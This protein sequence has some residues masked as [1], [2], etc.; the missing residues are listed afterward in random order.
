MHIQAGRVNEAFSALTLFEA[1]ATSDI[2]CAL[3]FLALY[4]LA[5]GR[6]GLVARVAAIAAAFPTTPAVTTRACDALIRE[7]ELLAPDEPPHPKAAAHTAVTVAQRCLDGLSETD[8]Q[9]LETFAYLQVCYGN[10]LRLAHLYD[11]SEAAL[12]SALKKRPEQGAWWFN[13]GLLQKQRRHFSDGVSTNQKARELLGDQKPLLW[14]LAICATGAGQ[15]AIA[16]DALS[17][18]GLS[19]YQSPSGMPQMDHLP[20][21]Q[22]RIA[23]LGPGHM[24]PSHVPDKAVSFELVWV[25]PL[26]PCHGVVQTPTYRQGSVDYGDLVLWDAVPVGTAEYEGK[27]TP[28]FPLLSVLRKGTEHRLRFIALQRRSGALDR[29][30]GELECGGHLFIHRERV[31]SKPCDTQQSTESAASK[32]LYGKVVLPD[33]VDLKAFYASFKILLAGVDAEFVMPELLELIGDTA[34]AGK[35]HTMWRGLERTVEKASQH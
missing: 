12:N 9:D 24:G 32:L 1:Q 30:E 26:S 34:G 14:N 27:K 4:R 33:S 28:R 22:V 21:V 25:S 17:G 2:G 7:A 31:A 10:A 3:G 13:L 16:V 23:T 6:E 20:P 18:L 19:A 11:R 8:R 5:P 35:A 29:L 15:G